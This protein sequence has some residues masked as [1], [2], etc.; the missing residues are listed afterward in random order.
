MRRLSQG[1][2][3]I[4]Q[5]YIAHRFG[6]ERHTHVQ[7]V[8]LRRNV[9]HVLDHPVE[10]LLRIFRHSYRPDSILAQAQ[11]LSV[12]VIPPRPQFF[13]AGRHPP[14]RNGLLLRREKEEQGQSKL[15]S[16]G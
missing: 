8:V 4:A 3:P 10:N 15:L 11:G 13:A 7:Y 16:K 9:A 2:D 6:V 14:V 5:R 1:D 12:K